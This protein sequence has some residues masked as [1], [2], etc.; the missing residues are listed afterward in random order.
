VHFLGFQRDVAACM[1]AVDVVAHTSITPEPFGRVIVEGMLARR[2]VVAARAGGVVES[3]ED[4]DNGLLCA[5][6]DAAALADALDTLKRDG[7]LRERLVASGRATAVRRFG[8][9]TYVERVE[10]ILAD[11]AKAAKA[12]KR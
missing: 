4:G 10:K 3:I 2:P 9:E 5:P 8:T 12:K 6:G 11:T 7:A 1:T